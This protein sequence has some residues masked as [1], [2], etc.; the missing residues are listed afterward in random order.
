MAI[1]FCQSFIIRKILIKASFYYLIPIKLGAIFIGMRINWRNITAIVIGMLAGSI[2]N[3]G[4]IEIG[5][6]LIPA[7]NGVD[8]EN[9]ESIKAH[10]HLYQPSQFL[11]PFIAH[12]IGTFIT[13]W[14][15]MFI[16][17]TR[18]PIR[19]VN[20]FGTLFFLCGVYMVYI[21]PAPIWFNLL[22]LT[23]AYFPMA[24]LGYQFSI[25]KEK[26]PIQ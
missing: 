5:S 23:I 19:Y 16:A 2:V 22:D 11:F 9:F 26:V 10:I 25:R 4:V 18:Y 12:C 14:L 20:M 21:L 24:Y 1:C 8:I 6:M 15:F 3:M 17:S 13:V 7:P